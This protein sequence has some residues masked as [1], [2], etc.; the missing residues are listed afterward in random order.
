MYVCA[1]I[2]VCCAVAVMSVDLLIFATHLHFYSVVW[3]NLLFVTLAD[4]LI[5]ATHLLFYFVVW[6]HCFVNPH[7]LATM[8]WLCLYL[9]M[10]T[11]YL[12]S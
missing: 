12:C 3:N 1:L 7:K 5:I 11:G 6:N 9:A 2:L 10:C 4:W 8:H